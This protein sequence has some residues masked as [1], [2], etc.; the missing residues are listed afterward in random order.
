MSRYMRMHKALT[1]TF[2]PHVLDIV[3][4][5]HR[6]KGHAGQPADEEETH[7]RIVIQSPILTPLTRVQQQ[8]LLNQAIAEEWGAGLHSVSWEVKK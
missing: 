7:F 6:H 2:M 3:D 8:R 1:T 5:S 4:E